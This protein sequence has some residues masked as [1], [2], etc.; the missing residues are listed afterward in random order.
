MKNSVSQFVF[1]KLLGWKMVGGF[2]KDL[3]KAIIIAAPHT[4]NWDFP[5]GLLVRSVDGFNSQYVIK[6]T[7][8]KRPVIG[9]ILRKIGGVGVDRSK[10]SN[11]TERIAALFDQHDEFII[12]ISPEGTR[13]YNPDWKTGFWYIAKQAGVPIVPVGFDWSKK[14]IVWGDPY[15]TTDDKDAD[16]KHFKDFFSPFKGKNPEWG[17]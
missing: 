3:K 4:S 7:W 5:V 8:L 12:T 16:I 1:S 6:D 15:F 13:K 11:M 10:S 2:P 17:G 14:Q 9:Q